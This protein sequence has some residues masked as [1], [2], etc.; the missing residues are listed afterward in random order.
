MIH[1]LP[2][3][4]Q[5]MIYTQL[6]PKHR[7]R[8]FLALPK[9]CGKNLFNK[10]K[11]NRLRIVKKFFKRHGENIKRNV[12]IIPLKLQEFMKK[13]LDDYLINKY[14]KEYDPVLYVT[15]NIVRDIMMNT[16]DPAPDAY[17]NI[18][19]V[20]EDLMYLIVKHAT[21][22]SFQLIIDKTH[23]LNH[24]FINSKVY[25]FIFSLVNYDNTSLLRYVLNNRQPSFEPYLVKSLG[26]F[27]RGDINVFF[28]YL[29]NLKVLQEYLPDMLKPHLSKIHDQSIE[30]FN[31]EIAL[32][33]EEIM[34][35][36]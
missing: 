31:T 16:I 1:T 19:T 4:I 32:W 28:G 26:Q 17:H 7:V 14:K 36:S 2:Q 12:K 21:P 9:E 18:T 24:I 33:V 35:A 15:P 13:H 11:D 10:D 8:L 23:L 27:E 6:T 30:Q 29:N 25:N 22:D 3:D 34:R 20:K 5:R